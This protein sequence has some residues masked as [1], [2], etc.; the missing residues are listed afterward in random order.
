MRELGDRC[1]TMIA[2][3]DG[4]ICSKHV[5]ARATF[6]NDVGFVVAHDSWNVS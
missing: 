3:E 2:D 6:P 5:R 4:G 1:E